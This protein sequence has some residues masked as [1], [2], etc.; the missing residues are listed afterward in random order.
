[1]E[2]QV[3]TVGRNSAL[4]G[5]RVTTRRQSGPVSR[6]RGPGAAAPT[7][8]GDTTPDHTPPPSPHAIPPDP[9]P[10]QDA[11]PPH[12]DPGERCSW[13]YVPLLHAAAGF[14]PPHVLAHAMRTIAKLDA[15]HGVDPMVYAA[16]RASLAHSNRHANPQTSA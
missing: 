11:R 9:L 2:Q 4:S 7:R 3:Y 8:G 16:P 13:L 10:W 1:M 5:R 12:G 6:G 14:L 15:R